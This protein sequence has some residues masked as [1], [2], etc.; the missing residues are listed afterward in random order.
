MPDVSRNPT[1]DI[2]SNTLFLLVEFISIGTGILIMLNTL[3][4]VEQYMEGKEIMVASTKKSPS[5][6]LMSPT[7]LICPSSSSSQNQNILSK[8]NQF[9]VLLINDYYF[10][11][12][13]HNTVTPNN[14][15]RFQS[16]IQ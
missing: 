14:Y 10:K 7:I 6:S 11:L 15:F 2:S 16:T 13:E 4:I 12:D 5:N 9:L 8:G 1:H 3:N